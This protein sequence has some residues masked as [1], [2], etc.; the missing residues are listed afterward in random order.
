MRNGILKKSILISLF[1]V[2]S[3]PNYLV[4]KEKLHIFTDIIRCQS[5]NNP[6]LN[7]LKYN[8]PLLD[9]LDIDYELVLKCRR[10]RETE[11]YRKY[12]NLDDSLKIVKLNDSIVAKY[13]PKSTEQF[14]V[15]TR[16]D[17]IIF[18]TEDLQLL[19]GYITR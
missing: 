16:N 14:F 7:I 2:F 1:V 15:L 10:T 4:T 8:T 5:C 12:Y 6:A 9:S 13:Q 19:I 3:F 11:D 17:T 18:T